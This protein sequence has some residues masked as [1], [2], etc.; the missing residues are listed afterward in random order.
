MLRQTVCRVQ[1]GPTTVS[2]V[3]TLTIL[4]FENLISVKEPLVN[5]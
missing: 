5:S 4:F 1:N 2:G 3:L